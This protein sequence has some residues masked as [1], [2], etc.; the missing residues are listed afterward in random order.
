[1][2]AQALRDSSERRLVVVAR[3]TS[4]EKCDERAKRISDE[5]AAEP[6]QIVVEK[7]TVK[8][9]LEQERLVEQLLEEIPK[10]PDSPF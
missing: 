2:L 4:K 9:F 10:A 7:G 1:M 5:L 8:S 3:C 6:K